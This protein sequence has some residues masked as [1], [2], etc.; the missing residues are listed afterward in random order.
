VVDT[1]CQHGLEP[2]TAATA[3]DR[4]LNRISADSEP[5]ETTN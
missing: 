4:L 1:Y 2:N 3:A 5:S